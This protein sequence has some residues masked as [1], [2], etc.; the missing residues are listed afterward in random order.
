VRLKPD[1]GPHA[2]HGG[3]DPGFEQKLWLV[4]PLLQRGVAGAVLRYLSPAG[5]QG[6]PGAVAMQVTYRLY[7]DDR[8]RIDYA[9][10]S[11]APTVINPTNHSYFNLAGDGRGTILGHR[12][13]LRS[14]A[15]VELAGGVPTGRLPTVAGTP[16][17]FRGPRSLQQCLANH[18]QLAG[19]RGCNHA[20]ALSGGKG[21]RLAARLSHSPS[22]R[23]LEVQTTEPAIQIYSGNWMP[24]TD[25]GA[26]GRLLM[27]HSGVALETQHFPDSPNRLDW[28]TTVL[29]PGELFTSTTVF[30]FG[31]L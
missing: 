19:H 8:L 29:R 2:L 30:R 15:Y 27:P 11:N 24:G 12:L 28:P 25:R 3:A 21:L 14:G 7:P 9:A 1:D 20:W 18:P 23:T 26:G 17:D 4:E 13:E 31:V 10:T 16:F 22:G 5:E 6:F